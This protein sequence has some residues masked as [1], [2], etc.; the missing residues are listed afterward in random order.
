LFTASLHINVLQV[1]MLLLLLL[2]L[3]LCCIVLHVP[4]PGSAG[5]SLINTLL[6]LP[7]VLGCSFA[8]MLP[9]RCSCCS[10]TLG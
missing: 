1:S 7:L 9:N 10:Q 8:A 2:M 4:L 3:L 6:L 5:K